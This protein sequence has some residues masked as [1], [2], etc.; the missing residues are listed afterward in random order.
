MRPPTTA[1]IPFRV[2]TA[3]PEKTKRVD[4]RAPHEAHSP[5]RPDA[6]QKAPYGS[7]RLYDP[8]VKNSRLMQNLKTR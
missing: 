7:Q 6:I 5:E 1:E 2:M 8:K 3:E 4:P